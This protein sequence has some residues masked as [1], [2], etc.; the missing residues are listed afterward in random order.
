MCED[1]R[2]RGGGGD[3]WWGCGVKFGVC[4]V[5]LADKNLMAR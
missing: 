4:V 2:M 1:V 3:L 5:C